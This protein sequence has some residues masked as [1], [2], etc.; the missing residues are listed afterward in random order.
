LIESGE[1]EGHEVHDRLAIAVSLR[2]LPQRANGRVGWLGQ[3]RIGV[4][5]AHAPHGG[6]KVKPAAMRYR[7]AALGATAAVLLASASA[8]AQPPSPDLM[9][10]L[11]ANAARFVAMKNRASYSIDGR[12]TMLDRKG[13]PDSVKEMSARVD[14]DGHDSKFIVIRYVEDGEDKTADAQEE[15]RKKA[16]Q[17]K[18]ERDKK[19][20]PI[21]ILA[22]EQ[23]NYIFDQTE[24]DPAVP[25]HVK[26]SFV[27]KAPD[28]DT[29][30]G[31]AWVD[32]ESANLISVGFKMS[33]PPM[34]VDYVHV[35]LEFGAPTAL[36]PA[37][38]RVVADGD[39]GILF[40]YRRRFHAT[41]TLSNYS[42][43]P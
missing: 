36:G 12:M 22:S 32:T 8:A 3:P 5:R 15:A 17:R 4:A 6:K 26:I 11:A 39:G 13:N 29:I 7:G 42:F 33:R 27:P 21:P 30:E 34:F 40:F 35:T 18:K 19:R 24:V 41:A 31:S 43:T 1:K 10:R 16:Q 9:S 2:A 20:L 38:S 14:A 37:I 25:T 28:E 23:P